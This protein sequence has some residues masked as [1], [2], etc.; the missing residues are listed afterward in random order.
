MKEFDQFINGKFIKSTS[1]DVIEILNPCTEEV[2]SLMPVGSVKDAELALDA[3]QASQHAWKSLTAIERAGYLHKMADVIREN[4]ISL[5]KTL[6]S[7]QAKVIGLAQVEIDVTA[8]YFDYN[9]GWARRIEGEIIQSDR[10]KEHIFLH[11]AP[12][13]V[14]VGILPWNFPFFVMARKIAPSLVT[15]NTCII[16]PSSVAPNTVMQFAKLIEKIGVPAGVLN[17]VCGKGSIVGNALSKSPITGIISLTGSVGAGQLVMQAASEN[18][19]KVSLELGGKAPAIVCAD[20]NLDLAV[21]AVVSSRVIFSGQVCNCAE[22]VYVE[23]SIYDQFMEKV[24]KKMSE[25][26]VEDAF[27]DNNPDMSSMV[28]KDQVDKVAEM[29]EYAKK[30]GAEVV[31][32]GTRSSQFDKGYFY[33]PTLLTN[34]TQN[35]QIIQEEVFGPVLPVM[36][37]G[38]L[39]EAIALANDCEFGLTS[40]IFSENFNKVMHACDQLEF[41]ETYVNREHFEAIQGFH[42]GWKKS[43]VGGA[44]GKHG[45]EEY[46]Q[47][48]VIYAQY[49]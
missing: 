46:L 39:D 8:D 37:F 22:R 12:I 47:T 25:V 34:V 41:G 26:K 13:G 42:A 24:T 5:A 1:T 31:V 19:T 15:G 7:E 20:A 10:K 36:K 40:S 48:K 17:F 49:R 9:A 23:D 4:R 28:S 33:Q 35:M 21:N 3:A 38:T 44:D 45:M 29:V 14:A 27:S 11:K 43:G 2:L 32:G 6:A 30:E 16:N 18:I